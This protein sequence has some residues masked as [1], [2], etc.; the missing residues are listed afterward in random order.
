MLPER[1][2]A[3]PRKGTRARVL[4]VLTLEP[5]TAVQVAERAG[6]PSRGRGREAALVLR[7]L[8]SDGLAVREVDGR[9]PRWLTS[10]AA[11]AA[12]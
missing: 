8:E 5:A 3:R 1:T 7:R 11:P 12:P 2:G 4:A 10:Q 6:I 9:V